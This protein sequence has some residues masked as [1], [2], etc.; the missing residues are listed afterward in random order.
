MFV[1]VIEFACLWQQKQQ[2]E[3]FVVVLSSLQVLRMSVFD[4]RF[5]WPLAAVIVCWSP[6]LLLS[7]LPLLVFV[8]QF[9][10][11]V[12]RFC[13][14]QLAWFSHRWPRPLN[15]KHWQEAAAKMN[16]CEA[17]VY[18]R[19]RRKGVKME[20]KPITTQNIMRRRKR[21]ATDIEQ[22]VRGGIETSTKRQ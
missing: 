20:T 22:A 13:R 3:R 18:G 15:Q 9:A 1:I 10:V 8:R 19:T 21:Q 17:L 7:S 4:Q 12:W 14:V 6:L 5:V 2:A 16:N 11:Q